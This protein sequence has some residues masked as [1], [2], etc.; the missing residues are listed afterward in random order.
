ML[1]G[2]GEQ[3][4]GLTAERSD[5]GVDGLDQD[6]L[7]VQL[8]GGSVND[9]VVRPRAARTNLVTVLGVEQD[10]AQLN[11]LGRVLCDIDAVLVARRG[12]VDDD[13]AV[14][15]TAGRGRSGGHGAQARET[16]RWREKKNTAMPA[17]ISTAAAERHRR[18]KL[19]GTGELW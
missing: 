16:E 12:Y 17:T 14:E 5:G 10:P 7:A 6:A 13:V 9:V 8:F 18:E 1:E 15:S 11:H 3:A 19:A 4:G 2:V